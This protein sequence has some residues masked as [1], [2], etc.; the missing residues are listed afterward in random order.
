NPVT[1]DVLKQTLT[2]YAARVRKGRE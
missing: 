2:V 1:L